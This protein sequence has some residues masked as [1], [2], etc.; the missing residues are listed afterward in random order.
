MNV[1]MCFRF[2]TCC[3]INP[4][5][6]L[7]TGI[8]PGD[9]KNYEAPVYANFST[10]LKLPLPFRTTTLACYRSFQD[11]LSECTGQGF[12]PQ[13]GSEQR[14]GDRYVRVI[15]DRTTTDFR[16]IIRLSPA[17]YYTVCSHLCGI[18]NTK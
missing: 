16:P 8:I 9:E 12:V 17:C 13:Q 6:P 18:G 1:C 4:S 2:H 14:T 7:I 15:E 5:H 10:H 3:I 11:S